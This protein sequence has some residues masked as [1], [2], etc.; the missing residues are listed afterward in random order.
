MINISANLIKLPIRQYFCC[1]Y[2][3]LDQNYTQVK[4]IK[5]Y[6]ID[7][8]YFLGRIFPVCLRFLRFMSDLL[9]IELPATMLLFTLGCAKVGAPTG[10]IRDTTPPRYIQ[11]TPENKSVNFN[12]KEIEFEF[13]EYIQLKDLN[14]ELIISPPLK[15]RPVVRI[16]DKS[17]RMNLNNE[18]LPNTTYTVNF[19]NAISDLNEGNLLPDFD[20]VFSTGDLL[21][22]LSVTGKTLNAFDHKPAKKEEEIM[23][24]LYENLSDS[25]PLIELPRYLG[26]ANKDGLFSINNVHA[27]TFRILALKDINSNLLFNPE[28]DA[29]AFLDSFII[30]NPETVKPIHFIKDTIKIKNPEIKSS[31]NQKK[32]TSE[33][34]TDTTIFQGKM[35]NAINVS[36]YYFQEIANQVFLTARKRDLPEK[37]MFTFSRSLHDSLQIV[38]LNFQ[39]SENWYISEVS[40]KNDSII[41]WITDSLIAKKD[42]LTFTVSYTTTD[43][44]NRFI[45]QTDTITLKY[46]KAIEKS[47]AGGRKTKTS[48]A[49]KP[50]SFL[51]L[52]TSITNKCIIDLN[53]PVFFTSEKPLGK[54][55]AEKIELYKTE[56]SLSIKQTFTCNLNTNNIR[57]FRISSAWEESS[58][59]RLL[60]TPGAVIDVYGKSNDSLE[61]KFDSQKAGFYGRILVTVEGKQYP[62]IMQV[63]DKKDRIIEIKCISQPGQTIFDFLPPNSYVLKAINDKN[64]NGNWDSGN[65]LK[66]IQPEPVFFYKMPIDIRSN[67]DYEIIWHISD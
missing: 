25:A 13:D 59:Y 65:Y 20:F 10:G 4:S 19:G 57:M 15:A 11:G 41:Y 53:K 48:L 36:L 42:T 27:D 63:I 58:H 12:R 52:K 16:R 30:I 9:F 51:R 55:D 49:V 21:D 64:G 46:Q 50:D 2:L 37:L 34:I 31:R 1:L 23:V 3:W 61:I 47:T 8:D 66:H 22:T 56:D 26:R 39:P 43:S 45:R 38:P 35:L 33:T 62:L 67:W 32:N 28:T 54:V 5:L 17:I 44:A 14:K 60:L 29:I 24:M 40:A 6:R 18:L 7:W